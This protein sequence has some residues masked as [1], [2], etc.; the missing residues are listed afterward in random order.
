MS[1]ETATTAGDGLASPGTIRGATPE[2]DAEACRD[3]YA[4]YVRDTAVSFEETVPTVEEFEGRIR[5]TTATHPWLVMEVGGKVVGYAYATQH[6][7]RAAYR[8]TA[9]VTVY[10]DGH[11]HQ[12][13]VGRRLYTELLRRLRLQGFRLAVAGITLPNAGSVGLHE[14]MGFEPVGV[15]NRIGWKAGDWHDVGWWQ[16][17]LR[18]GTTAAPREPLLPEPLPPR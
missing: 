13:G 14:A 15:Y 11:H 10:V 4:P 12:A 17:D 16:L 8:W 2:R 5:K 18:P 9:E 1:S 7:P 3:I 6:R